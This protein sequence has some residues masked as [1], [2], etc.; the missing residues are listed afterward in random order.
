M[1]D[2][3]LF[4]HRKGVSL[5]TGRVSVSFWVR[6]RTFE[7]SALPSS[8]LPQGL[9]LPTPVSTLTH[10]TTNAHIDGSRVLVV[11]VANVTL[12]HPPPH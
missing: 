8:H 1:E 10:K 4:E 5:S 9:S 11:K 6:T 7:G 12:V 3:P 2:F